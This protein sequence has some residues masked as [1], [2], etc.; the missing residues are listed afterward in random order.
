MGLSLSMSFHGD[1]EG[2]DIDEKRE[3][4]FILMIGRFGVKVSLLLL[5]KTTNGRLLFQG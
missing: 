5:Q 4:G 2:M 3:L 1:G